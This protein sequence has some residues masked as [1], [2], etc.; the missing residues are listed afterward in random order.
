MTNTQDIPAL[1]QRTLGD[2]RHRID[3]LENRLPIAIDRRLTEQKHRL[4]RFVL[5]LQGFDPQVL[6]ARGYSITLLNGR[7][8][9]DPAVLHDGDLIETRVEKGTVLSVVKDKNKK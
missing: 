7:A 2:Q 3:Q 6:L 9:R 8:V 4:E 5:Q 1:M